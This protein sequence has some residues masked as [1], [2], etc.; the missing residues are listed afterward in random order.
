MCIM[1]RG[2]FTETCDVMYLIDRI[3]NVNS[4]WGLS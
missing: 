1:K 3:L 4:R 2:R